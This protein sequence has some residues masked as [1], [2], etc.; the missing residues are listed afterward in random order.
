[1]CIFTHTYHDPNVTQLCTINS[2][3]GKCR[4]A[5]IEYFTK[6]RKLLLPPRIRFF[7]FILGWFLYKFLVK[8]FI[9]LL[10]LFYHILLYL[11]VH[12][13]INSYWN[14]VVTVTVTFTVF[15]FLSLQSFDEFRVALVCKWIFCWP[16][17][18]ACILVTKVS[19]RASK[20]D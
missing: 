9:L 18:W 10:Y 8:I 14:M 6:G 13:A 15:E 11:C 5:K 2:S 1:M 7:H 3:T 17:M 12:R 19:N 20:S 16:N 4:W